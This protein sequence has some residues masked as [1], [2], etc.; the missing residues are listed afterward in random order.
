MVAM[1]PGTPLP[2]LQRLALDGMYPVRNAARATLQSIGKPIPTQLSDI[3]D[4]TDQ[5]DTHDTN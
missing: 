5:G 3:N 4:A 1:N 2:A